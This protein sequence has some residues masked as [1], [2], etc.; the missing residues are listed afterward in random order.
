MD[1]G[2]NRG[3]DGNLFMLINHWVGYSPPDPGKAGSLVNTEEVL[4]RRI[5]QCITER[6]VWPNIVAVDF[7]ERGALVKVV[8]SYNAEV[9]S[10]LSDLRRPSGTSGSTTTTTTVA[11]SPTTLVPAVA[12]SSALRTPTVVSSLTGG[13]PTALCR[14]VG[15]WV[16]AMAGWSLAELSKPPAAAGLPSL[17]FGPLVERQMADVIAAAP[18]E[19]V[20]RFTAAQDHSAAAVQALRDAGLTQ[21]QVDQLADA[22]ADQLGGDQPDAAVAAVK[23][24]ELLQGML[25]ADRTT[26]LAAAFGR[27]NPLDPAV[28]DL[29]DVSD[30][31]A[32]DSGYACLVVG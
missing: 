6:G 2:P 19:L 26:A 31:V 12:S 29:G 16:D 13:D 23:V 8:D 25:G 20:V 27:S 4:Q 11:G 18:D 3:S 7:A 22:M 14:V 30:Q 32:T 28:F 5:E 10:R 17:L 21:A 24:N 1:C 9:R 15:P